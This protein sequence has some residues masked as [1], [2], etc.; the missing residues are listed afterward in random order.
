MEW[1]QKY[2]ILSFLCTHLISPELLPQ[3]FGAEESLRQQL[4]AGLQQNTQL[5][6]QK[7]RT[8]LTWNSD[9]TFFLKPDPALI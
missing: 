3:Q 6:L 8:T 9:L 5:G 4:S 1:T 2:N 7:T